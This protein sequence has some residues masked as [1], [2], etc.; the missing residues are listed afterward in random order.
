MI[1][2]HERVKQNRQNVTTQPIHEPQGSR[3]KAVKIQ[4]LALKTKF[5]HPIDHDF[6]LRLWKLRYVLKVGYMDLKVI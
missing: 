1:H 4:F 5:L 3:A 2:K 6:Y